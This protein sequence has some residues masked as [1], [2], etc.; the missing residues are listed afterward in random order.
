MPDSVRL[1]KL[2]N[3]GDKLLEIIQT[4]LNLEERLEKWLEADISILWIN[5]NT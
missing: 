3:D 1:W 5:F 2:N 4:E